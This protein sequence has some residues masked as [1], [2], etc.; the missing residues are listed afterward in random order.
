[1]SCK[2][3]LIEEMKK[4]TN[5]SPDI[6]YKNIP[7]N[8]KIITLIYSNSVSSSSSINEYILRRIDEEKENLKTSDLYNY[9]KN[10]IPNN[11]MTKINTI[12]DYLYYLFH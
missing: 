1:M 11:S 8:N 12:D 6:T 10:Y 3:K 5:F 4:R 7:I 9:I 2:E